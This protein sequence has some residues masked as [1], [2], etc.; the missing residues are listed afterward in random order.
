MKMYI[1]ENP[2]EVRYGDSLCISVANDLET[3]KVIAP[4]APSKRLKGWLNLYRE[5]LTRYDT[6]EM[7]DRRANGDRIACIEIDVEEGEGLS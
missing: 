3:A 7:A 4:P 6:R 2:Y 5:S 1:W